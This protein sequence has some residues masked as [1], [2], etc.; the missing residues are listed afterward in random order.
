MTNA[1][2]IVGKIVGK[3]KTV[4]NVLD[5]A[6]NKKHYAHEAKE[7]LLHEELEFPEYEKKECEHKHHR[8]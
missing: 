2:S 6:Y 3:G 1:G 5:K 4:S 7:T 8:G